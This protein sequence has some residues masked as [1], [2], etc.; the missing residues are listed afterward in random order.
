MQTLFD[1]PTTSAA[2]LSHFETWRRADCMRHAAEW[3]QTAREQPR[4]D[5]GRAF[6]AE[7]RTVAQRLRDEANEPATTNEE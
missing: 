4:T 2:A 7:C 6:A 5:R 1:E 3:E